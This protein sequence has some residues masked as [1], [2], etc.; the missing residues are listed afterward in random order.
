MNKIRLL[1]VVALSLTAAA[2]GGTSGPCDGVT[3]T[4]VPFSAG[5]K[6]SDIANAFATAKDN[7]TFAF[8]A[9]TYAFTNTIAVQNKG[10]TITGAGKDSTSS[11]STI[12]DFS[13]LGASTDGIGIEAAAGSDGFTVSNL[14]VKDTKKNGIKAVSTVGVTFHSVK[15][16]WTSTVNSSHGDYAVYP[17]HCQKVLV[18]DSDISG[19]SDAGIYVGQ[20]QTIIVRNNTAHENVAGIEIE[21]S[22][23]ADVYGN[24]ATGNTGGILVFDL[25]GSGNQYDGHQVRVYNNIINAN[26]GPNFNATG[27]TVAKVPSGT[28]TFVLATRDVEIYGNTISNNKTTASSVI[29][30]LVPSEAPPPYDD[31]CTPVGSCY[32]GGISKDVYIHDNTFTSNGITP[33]TSDLGILLSINLAKYPGGH[34]PDLIVDGVAGTPAADGTANNPNAFCFANNGAA[35]FLNLHFDAFLGS[36]GTDFTIMDYS[37]TASA[38]YSCTGKTQ[39]AVV[40][41]F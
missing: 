27:S 26:N 25:P 6:E 28:G 11:A 5:A 29:S 24:T 4:C 37:S 9:G 34:V 30:Y 22:Y 2:C 35:T 31:G 13:G 41:W 36:G 8:G 10:I 15:V 33:D 1:A 3:G 20:S 23:F 21:N 16:Y 32:L 19:S 12:F 14:A 38:N 7:T 17:V 39:P 18:E 40:A